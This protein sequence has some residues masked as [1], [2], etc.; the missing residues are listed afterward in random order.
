MSELKPC[1]FCGSNNVEAVVSEYNLDGNKYYDHYVICTDCKAT[2]DYGDSQ[3][4]AINKWN[5]RC[6]Q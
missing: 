1:P 5:R 2:T 6:K 4:D 3:Q